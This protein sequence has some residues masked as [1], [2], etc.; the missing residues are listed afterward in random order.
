[1]DNNNFKDSNILKNDYLIIKK[2]DNLKNYDLGLL[3]GPSPAWRKVYNKVIEETGLKDGGEMYELDI[4][5][6][7][8]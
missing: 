7:L 5:L 2:T 3:N 1:M 8:Q 4:K 6:G